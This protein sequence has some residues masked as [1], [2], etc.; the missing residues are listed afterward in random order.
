MC[1]LWLVVDYT[2]SN[3]SVMNLLVIC[4]DRLVWF[5]LIKVLMDKNIFLNLNRVVITLYIQKFISYI[6]HSF[7]ILSEKSLDSVVY[8]TLFI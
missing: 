1:K 2:A 4:V 5:S 7:K 6:D 8:Q 3:S